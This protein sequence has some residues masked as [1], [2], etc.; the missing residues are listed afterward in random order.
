LLQ[1]HSIDTERGG[2]RGEEDFMRL[3][4]FS[5]FVT[6]AVGLAL[7]QNLPPVVLEVDVENVRFYHQDS[8]DFA[9]YGSRAE[10]TESA[11][12]PNF[13]YME[14]VGDV[15]A[16]NGQR[17]RGT[18]T[19]Q[20]TGI[21]LNKDVPRPTF[22]TADIG[23]GA[24][25]LVYEIDILGEDG[26]HIAA[27]FATG[28]NTMDPVPAGS[29][30]QNTDNMVIVGGTGAFFGARGQMLFGPVLPGSNP[31][32]RGSITEDPANRRMYGGLNFRRIVYLIPEVRP[33]VTQVMHAD[34]S[35][36][37]ASRP[38]RPGE[39]VVLVAHGL[40]PT[41]PAVPPGQAFPS[42]EWAIVNSPV[43]ARVDGVRAA[44]LNHFGWPNRVDTFRVDV[45]IPDET[46][47]GSS[48]LSLT[49]AWIP[50]VAIS[51]PIAR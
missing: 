29:H 12:H 4:T 8:A 9:R 46:R 37:T 1:D 21:R 42:S 15:V 49:A 17:V 5:M 41:R 26:N 32:A 11:L 33:T 3:P 27:L 22:G 20:A 25:R 10:R 18:I 7:G 47:A 24:N 48:S 28:R 51:I 40:G 23:G 39:T 36:V 31:Q 6:G 44:V 34:F 30:V 38:A 19:V 35:P 13:S 43:E 2:E 50:G 14:A 45:R 16:V